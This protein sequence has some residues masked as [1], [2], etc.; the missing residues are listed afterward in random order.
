MRISR[1][2]SRILLDQNLAQ[3][4]R[5]LL[6]GHDV[7]HAIE[8]GWDRLENGALLTAAEGAGFEV[9]LTADNR[10]RYQQNL[11]R[12]RISLVVLSN[13]HWPTVRA[14]VEPILQALGLIAE[15]SYQEVIFERRPLRRRPPPDRSPDG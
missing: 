4:L 10:I 2:V 12:R 9:M 8:M 13:N 15:G 14:N 11:A 5:D 7:R 1:R 3:D 6:P